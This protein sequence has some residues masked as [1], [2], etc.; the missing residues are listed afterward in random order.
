MEYT[1]DYRLSAGT[2]IDTPAAFARLMRSVYTWMCAGL[3][4]TAL[5]AMTMASHM[6]WMYAIFSGGMIWVLL[7]AELG[8]VFYLSARIMKMSF[9]AAGLCFAGYAI[10]NGITL[11]TIFIAYTM[12]SIAQ[13]FAVTAGT[14]GAMSLVGFV[15]KKD[16]ST[17]GRM[18]MMLLIGLIIATVV[19]IF[20]Q[21][22]G[23]GMILNYLGVIIFV[24]LT[25]YDTQKIK[26]MVSEASQYGVSDQTQKFALM[27]SLT[28]YLDFINLFIY[29][30]RFFGD[31]K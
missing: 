3:A 10:L 21:N 13:T 14:F 7:I 25:A 30:L 2:A 18:L 6:E 4:M 12:E 31:R 1:K 8:L 24:G 15:V 19:N 17:M 29:L 9:V 20:W 5:T 23:L 27:G 11:S 28:L 16:L 22:S 26:E